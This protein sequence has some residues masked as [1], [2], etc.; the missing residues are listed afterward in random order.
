MHSVL[1]SRLKQ[2]VKL[3]YRHSRW[4]KHV[5]DYADYDTINLHISTCT[6]GFFLLRNH[7]CMVRNHL[8][9]LNIYFSVFHINLNKVALHMSLFRQTDRRY[10]LYFKRL[11]DSR[12]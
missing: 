11:S 8:K 6:C 4:P 2:L 9:H 5:A 10:F 12:R 1:H 7:Q 3:F